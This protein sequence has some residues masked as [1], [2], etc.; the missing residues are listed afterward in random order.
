MADFNTGYW[1]WVGEKQCPDQKPLKPLSENVVHSL[2][3]S[4]IN[5]NSK[6]R[7]NV[8]LQLVLCLNVIALTD[9]VQT[10]TVLTYYTGHPIAFECTTSRSSTFKSQV[11]STPWRIGERKKKKHR[12]RG[13]TRR[14]DGGRRNNDIKKKTRQRFKNKKV[15]KKF[16]KNSPAKEWCCEEE[17]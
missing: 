3:L 9:T 2:H 8:H 6:Q 10:N 13:E 12:C 1:P 17:N 4:A 7:D 15:K 16:T 5:K 11:H 14:K